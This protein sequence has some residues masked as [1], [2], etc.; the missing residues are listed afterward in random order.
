MLICPKCG[1]E[2]NDGVVYCSKCGT[3]VTHQSQ[4]NG[5]AQNNTAQQNPFQNSAQQNY[6][7][8][9]SDKF[10]AGVNSAVNKTKTFFFNTADETS[11]QDVSDVQE[12]KILALVSYLGYFFFIPMIV[13]PYSRYLRFHGNQG[14]TLCLYLV[15][16]SILNTVLTSIIGIAGYSGIGA[17]IAVTII[18]SIISIIL[19]GSFVLLAAI[20]IYNAV[21]GFAREL[22]V[23]GKIRILREY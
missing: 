10:K 11:M 19:Y 20:G 7:G 5:A 2:L 9:T 3:N 12:N 14:L 17:L 18:N 22:P 15:A 13:K 23:I 21:K 1:T 16:V 4:P 8:T 6:N